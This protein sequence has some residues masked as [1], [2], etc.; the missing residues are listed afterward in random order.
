MSTEYGSSTAAYTVVEFADY[1]C[2]YC[3]RLFP[4]IHALAD[5]PDIQ[6]KFKH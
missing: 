2:P 5:D 4:D 1:E 3:G 6:I